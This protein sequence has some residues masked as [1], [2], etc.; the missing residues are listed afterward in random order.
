MIVLK[1]F[2]Y[3]GIIA[4]SSVILIHEPC[5]ATNNIPALVVVEP[6]INRDDCK[7]RR[8][9]V[10]PGTFLHKIK[11]FSKTGIGKIYLVRTPTGI[12]GTI[13][14]YYVSRFHEKIHNL[15]YV[16]HKFEHKISKHKR[17]WFTIG[18]YFPFTMVTD[19]NDI[20][21]YT[22]SIPYVKYD[23]KLGEHKLVHIDWEIPESE[24]VN[25]NLI[26]E[27]IYLKIKFPEWKQE[28]YNGSEVSASWGCGN[29]EERLTKV[30]ANAK[31]KVSVGV[32]FD[33]WKWAK[34]KVG[35]DAGASIET[36]KTRIKLLADDNFEHK[37]TSWKLLGSNNKVL[38]R[39]VVEKIRSCDC[40]LSNKISYIFHFPREFHG[41]LIEPITVN[42]KWSSDQSL[43][44]GGSFPVRLT[45]LEDYRE[46]ST[47]LESYYKIESKYT[48][49]II[50]FIVYIAA[51]IY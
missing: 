15:A 16:K 6:Y 44:S 23:I 46:F 22:I 5:Y 21:I 30:Q 42:H 45:T 13:R 2:F 29:T 1:W 10:E 4:I 24:I 12:T 32:G 31:T 20:D 37:M 17:K 3:L 27:E 36:N 50:D 26:S 39:V 51:N 43:R 49:E 18:E 33:F 7:R 25:F 34:A 28:L 47:K 11:T 38:F 40:R 35:I 48:K 41:R 8:L 14:P 9:I 19:S